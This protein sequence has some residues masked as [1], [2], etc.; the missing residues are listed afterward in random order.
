MV[1]WV[2]M[3]MLKAIPPSVERVCVVRM[4]TSDQGQVSRSE[5]DLAHLD[6]RI[7][8]KS[9]ICSFSYKLDDS[10]EAVIVYYGDISKALEAATAP[11][12]NSFA[13]SFDKAKNYLKMG[14]VV[15]GAARQKCDVESHAFV[16]DTKAKEPKLVD[17]MA[18]SKAQCSEWTKNP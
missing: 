16:F 8:T 5:V 13:Q 10:K 7:V 14:Y 18:I 11:P 2:S 15:V 3:E 1:R 6:K 9:P 4:V 17:S 12:D